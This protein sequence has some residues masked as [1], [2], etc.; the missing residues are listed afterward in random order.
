MRLACDLYDEARFRQR[1]GLAAVA[2]KTFAD[3]VA[4][5][6]VELRNDLAAGTGKKIY[7]EYIQAIKKYFPPFFGDR[8]LQ[9]LKHTNIEDFE[10]WR[11]A[12]VGKL[13]K[14]ST[15]MNVASA[16]LRVCSTAVQ[17]GFI[18]E[19]VPLPKMSRR[20]AKGTT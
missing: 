16:F 12:K 9:N 4:I 8:Q 2:T 1:L 17:S 3:I 18:S 5:R 15:L 14:S 6:V 7:V 19:R 10:S 11:N 20:G 13:P